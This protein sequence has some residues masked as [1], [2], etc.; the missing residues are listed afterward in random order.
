MDKQQL[1]DAIKAYVRANSKYTD[2]LTVDADIE[3]D[4]NWLG[5]MVDLRI[6]SLHENDIGVT[7][8]INWDAEVTTKLLYENMDIELLK[9]IWFNEIYAVKN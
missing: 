2:Y 5:I 1:I 8:G 3:G 7:V 6:D 9:N 4:C